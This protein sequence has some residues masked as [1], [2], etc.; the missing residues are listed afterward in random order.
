MKTVAV[1]ARFSAFGL[2]VLLAVVGGAFIIGETL[3][4]PGRP[5][6]VALAVFAVW[7]PDPATRL[8]TVLAVLVAV[9]IM[10]DLVFRV[11]S[12]MRSARSVRPAPSPL[13]WAWASWACAGR[14]RLA[15]CCCCR[16]RG[17]RWRWRIWSG[18]GRPGPGRRR[19]VPARRVGEAAPPA[20][21][22]RGPLRGEDMA[23]R[24]ALGSA[25]VTGVTGRRSVRW[26]ARSVGLA[27]L[28]VGAVAAVYAPLEWYVFY[29]FSS[30]GRFHYDGFG[31]GS[32]WF[33]LLIGHSVAYYLVAALLIP[34]GVG[35]MRLRRWVRRP[36]VW[37]TRT[38]LVAGIIV[39]ANVL[40]VVL[41]PALHGGGGPSAKGLA[42]A[43]LC[44]V[45]LV[46]LPAGLLWCLRHPAVDEI[47]DTRD[48]ARSRIEHI[49]PAVL[50]VLG[51]QVAAVALLHWDIFFHAIVPLFGTVYHDRAAMPLL[52]AAVLILTGLAVGTAGRRRWAWWGTLLCAAASL[53][54]ITVT[55]TR[56]SV[57][58]LATL[59]KLPAD[60]L[61]AI[62]DLPALAQF[63]LSGL[64]APP[65]GI[66]LWLL[67]KHRHELAP[68]AADRRASGR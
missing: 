17:E 64:L 26:L 16:R 12:V 41:V 10:V 61:A 2:T 1:I 36:S 21:C 22:P 8:L 56:W 27:E 68:R 66:L 47:L 32:A 31:V 14:L 50:A 20:R 52:G 60:E 49:P 13:P 11:I 55:F 33:A 48:V 3:M 59:A 43:A 67:V 18:A 7:R 34:L 62:H 45:L 30:G 29:M 53:V 5:P 28:A 54:S 38:W 35:T 4:D 23:L 6:T 37:L 51:M 19:P 58:D 24:T 63:R 65:L 39:T 40:G 44:A 15:G 9:F 25:P 46:A 57:G 42:I